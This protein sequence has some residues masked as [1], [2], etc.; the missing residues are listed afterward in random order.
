MLTKNNSNKQASLRNK[1]VFV[2]PVLLLLIFIQHSVLSVVA[3]RSHVR[4]ELSEQESNTSGMDIRDTALFNL[5]KEKTWLESR[6]KVAAEDSISLSVNLRDSVLQLELKGVVLK[7]SK[8]ASF[9]AD[10]FF[11]KLQPDLYHHLFG[12]VASGESALATIEKVPL[13]IKKAPKDSAEF[14]SQNHAMDTLNAE[15]V[16]WLLELNNGIVLKIEGVGNPEEKSRLRNKFWRH[17]DQKKVVDD[18]K[19]TL[20]FEVPEYQPSIALIVSEAD[21]RAIYRALPNKPSV[22]IRF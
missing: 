2:L 5:Y 17:L 8:I 7:T 9:K 6:L 20:R 16:H 13:T 1:L 10:Q 14:A 21:A 15:D 22:C 3:V 11:M 4:K 12:S 18:L 19:K